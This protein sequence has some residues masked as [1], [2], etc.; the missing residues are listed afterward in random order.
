MKRRSFLRHAM[1]AAAVPG[2]FSSLGFTMPGRR[3]MEYFLRQ[4]AETDRVLVMIFLDGGN[5]GL[6]TVVPLDR[7]SALNAVRSRVVLDEDE[8]LRLPQSQIGLHPVM[9]DLKELYEESKFQIIQNVGYDNP[10]FSHFRSTDIWMS[11]SSSSEIVGSG[12]M[13]RHLENVY[14]GYP[15]AFPTDDMQ[16]PLSVE[17]GYGSSL[18]FQGVSVSTSYTLQNAD[19]FYELLNNVEQEAPDTP[20]GEKL[21]FIRLIARQSQEY[22]QRIVDVASQV[23]NH[24]PYPGDTE[25][26]Q[27]GPQLKIVSKLI[28]GG[29]RTPVYL[30]RLGGFDTHDTQVESD[31]SVGEHARLLKDLND[32]IA[33]FMKDL[34]LHDVADK[35]L[36]MTFS[37]FGR[38]I[39]SN[40]SNGTDH[41]TAAPM[42]FFGNA[43]KGG[44][45]GSNPVID[46]QMTYADNLPHAFDFRQLYSSVLDQW[47]GIESSSRNAVLFGDFESLEII[48][49]PAI[50]LSVRSEFD[51]SVYP[52][53]LNGQ[54]TIRYEGDGRPV[55]IDLMDM[56][57]QVVQT[58][59]NGLSTRGLNRH[60][61]NTA[62]IP[63][64]RYFVLL[65]SEAG[66][67]VF[68]VVK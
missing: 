4:A 14:P 7:M 53:P 43:V 5:D 63:N 11:G 19:S 67:Q 31:H 20:A 42:F 10:D 32:S 59:F 18:L 64:G 21:K 25:Y 3:S 22:G 23:D 50:T 33:A 51:L 48:G 12:W 58:I 68:S 1:H 60:T 57:G 35:V 40:A 29:S 15:E 52:N 66:R 34:E 8:L 55:K 49:D 41:G 26:S 37:E 36:G 38:T 61:W 62:T 17:I 44:V 24:V 56:K 54:S 13:G 6:N 65:R 27:L 30:V 2:V 28:A 47:F 39:L 46:A 16:D 45:V 9:T